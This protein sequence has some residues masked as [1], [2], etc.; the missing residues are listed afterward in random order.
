ML[1]RNC[2]GGV[3]FFED[4]VFLLLNDKNEWVLP[5]GV[6]R[7]S[8]LSHETALARVKDEGGL[9]PEIL[10]TAGETNYEFYSITRRQPVCNRITWYIMRAPDDRMR[11]AFEQGF[12]D[13]GYFPVA[14]A[15]KKIT[16]SQDRSLVSLAY[17]NYKEIVGG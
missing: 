9:E 7:G 15:V 12:R 16:Y 14:E 4:S 11:I 10:T 17:K 1:V 8:A 2:A 6:I 3:V 13:G 5:K